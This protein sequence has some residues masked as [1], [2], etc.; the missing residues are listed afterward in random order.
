MFSCIGTSNT[1]FAKSA[2]AIL[3]VKS[4]SELSLYLFSGD[5]PK[6]AT[7]YAKNYFASLTV[8]ELLDLGFTQWEIDN[9][10]LAPG[11]TAYEYTKC[12]APFYY[13]PV[14][15]ESK[16]IAIMTLIDYGDDVYSAQF[17]KSGFADSL[18]EIK[19]SVNEPVVLII[20]QEG[21][22]ALDASNNFILLDAFIVGKSNLSQGYNLSVPNITFNQVISYNNV[23]IAISEETKF[24]E[25]IQYPTL[26]NV[27]EN[28][29]GVPFVGNLPNGV[30]WASSV[31]SL[32]RARIYLPITATQ[33]R[34]LI[35]SNSSNTGTDNN[36]KA[37]IDSYVGGSS[38]ISTTRPTFSIV[39]T[40]IDNGKPIY[41]H[42]KTLPSLPYVGH[43]MVVRGYYSFTGPTSIIR[44]SLMDPNKTSYQ[45]VDPGGSYIVG[46]HILT[47]Q[48][49]V[50]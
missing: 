41:S 37:I 20:A 11:V 24:D 5:I 34:D 21:M 2:Q 44:I 12:D 18:N 13:F 33:L 39:K 35:L 22:Y 30:C 43:A 42:W 6:S 15:D 17:G 7:E 23:E 45:T 14:V 8:F 47:W 26:R 27:E 1:V 49:A 50:Y 9:L 29:I 10:R 48:T 36:I 3:S 25:T 16:I 28:Y 4:D 31:A 19:T 38:T 32:I 40:Q 46:P